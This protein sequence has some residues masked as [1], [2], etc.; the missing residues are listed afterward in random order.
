MG[1]SVSDRDDLDGQDALSD[2]EDDAE[3]IAHD[4]P[5]LICDPDDESAEE[6]AMHIEDPNRA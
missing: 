3:E 6:A 5:E 4:L 2:I 1:A